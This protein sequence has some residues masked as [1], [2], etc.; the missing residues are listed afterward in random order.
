MRGDDEV[1][2]DWTTGSVLKAVF[3]FSLPYILSYFLQTF[4]G[5]ADLLIVGQFAGVE[6]TTAVAIGSQ[7]MHMLT[8][9]IVGLSMGTTVVVARSVGAGDRASIA[10]QIGNSAAL[11]MSLSLVLT[12][13][14]I[15]G[16]RPIVAWMSTPTEAVPGTVSYLLICFAGIPFITA[17]NLISSIFRGLGDSV[18]PM[19]FIAV[20]CA[21]NVLLDYLFMGV[22][23]WG[24]AG[25][26]LATVLSQLLSAGAGLVLLF[27]R[28]RDS[29]V[30]RSDFLLDRSV[31]AR[32]FGIGL[33]IAVQ[34]GLIQVAFIVITIIAN[35]R[36]LTDAAAVGIV[37]KVICFIFLVPS[38]MLSTVSALSA[39]NI[40][41]NKWGRAIQT[42]WYAVMIATGF[43]VVVS[44]LVQF[45]PDP[46]I[47]L[48]THDAAVV[49][50]GGEYF[51]GCILD[52]IFAGIHF[53]FSGFFC[54]CGKS[55]I[56][57]AH[58]FI[59]IVIVRVPGVYFASKWWPETLFP[60]GIATALGSIVSVVICLVVFVWLLRR[61]R[62]AIRGL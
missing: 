17:Y 4:Y 54:A 58:N 27:H 12:G 32:I 24:P 13:F 30:R 49:K 61:P 1:K 7:V 25:A 60:M 28:L 31:L 5:M 55:I 50:A 36:G 40:G 47:A 53:S 38:A 44:I 33:P 62:L 23:G 41:A 18:S 15:L 43:G 26:A 35:Q 34:D 45:N 6:S 56:S 9:I 21:A 16:V 46:C 59:S 57:F 19:Y 20:A 3:C 52:C 2:G 22:F 8:V 37:E 51:R 10:R 42:L 39:Q 11:F 14:L 29:P 48:F